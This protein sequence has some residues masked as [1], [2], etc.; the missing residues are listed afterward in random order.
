VIEGDRLPTL[1]ARRVR[2]RWLDESDVEAL[3]AVFADPEVTRYWSAPPLGGVDDARCLLDDIR[4]HFR[5]KTLFQWG[6]ARREDDRVVGTCTLDRPDPVNLR[7]EIGFAL[8]REYQ[9]RGYMREALA[10][11]L[12]YAFGPLGLRR[13]EA[14][15]DPRNAASIRLLE[16]LG[17]RREGHL[18]Q[19][20]RVGDEVQD[21]LFYGLLRDDR[22]SGG[23]PNAT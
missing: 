5:E 14:D 13:I 3:H 15:V 2:L 20:W 11:L 18:R 17:F 19:R 12:D 21:S 10:T 16:K 1:E 7:A 8:G 6:V 4:R 9:G 23:D 22:R